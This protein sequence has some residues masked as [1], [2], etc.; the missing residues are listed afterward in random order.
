VIWKRLPRRLHHG[1]EATLVEHLGELRT[2][3]FIALGSIV[4]GFLVAFAF[5]DRLISWLEKPLPEAERELVVLGVTEAFFTTVKVSF[6]AG[7]AL[8]LP[9]VLYQIWAFLAPAF[10]ENVQRVV[11]GFVVIATAL[12]ACGVAFG[13]YI[14]LPAALDF[15][16]GYQEDLFS[17]EIRASYYFSFVTLMLFAMGLVFELPIWILALVRLRVI[18]SATLRRNRRIGYVLAV[19]LAMLLPTV[20][21]VSL[22][23]ETIPVLIL[24]EASIWLAVFMERRWERS[25]DEGWDPAGP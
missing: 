6:Y 11:S 14:V 17:S 20:D 1:E 25:W 5:S 10:E 13:Y 4:P 7:L 23:L 19:V 21:P 9:V 18:S 24:F 22:V 2:R 15:L 16:V 12:F 8:A 3:L